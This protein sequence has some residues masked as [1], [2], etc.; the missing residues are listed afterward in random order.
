VQP[1]AE[2]VNAW[3]DAVR[4]A[5]RRGELLEAV[6]VAERGLADHPDDVWLRH[7]AVLALARAGSTAEAERRYAE[8]GLG[9]VHDE[10]AEALRARIAKDMALLEHGAARRELAALAARLYGEV[11]ER[12]GGHYPGVNAA[13]MSLVA[14][15][16]ATARGL[17]ERVLAA[18]RRT[19][20]GSYYAAASEAEAQLLLGRTAAA[21]DALE[22]AVERD[23]GDHAAVASTRRQLR[24]VCRTLGVDDAVLAVIAG[25][26]VAHYCGHRIAAAGASGRLPAE[27]EQEVAQRIAAE[28]AR[29]PV[30]YAYGSL[31]SGADI[32]WAEALRRSGA[33]VHVVLPFSADEFVRTSVAD[34]GPG[35]A[36]RFERCLASAA[37][38]S[39]AT[40][41]AYLGDDVLYRYAADLAMGLALLRARFLDADVRQLAVWDGVAASGPAGTAADVAAWTARGHRT[42]IVR[43]PATAGSAVASAGPAAAGGR[44][45]RAMLFGDIKGFSKLTDEQLPAFTEHVLGTFASVL[46]R[47]RDAVCFRNTWGDGLYVVLRDAVSAAACAADLQEAMAGAALERHALPGH[48]ALRLGAHVGPVFPVLDPVIG[49]SAFMGS[50]I[51]RTARIEPVTPPG[52]VYV[53]EQFAAALEIEGSGLRCDYVGHMPAAK[54]FGRL[55]MYRLHRA[56]V[57]GGEPL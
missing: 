41:D 26:S 2:R 29:E 23:D 37:A 5:E 17:A 40:E 49:T 11:F 28:V 30:A 21:A 53:T 15:D 39:Y 48:L 18:V 20:D 54:D 33:D 6:D 55:R 1:A 27:A 51:S 12:T 19:G 56:A 4:A 16:L 22:R 50:H 7:R 42:S 13:T 3:H 9:D 45:V 24:L 25:P 35:W 52:T 47:H 8:Y 36:A 57:T 46:E 31:A 14:G 10:D 38:V 32:L 43:P 44:V 34:S